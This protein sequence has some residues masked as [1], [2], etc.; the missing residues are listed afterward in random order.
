MDSR[1]TYVP[2]KHFTIQLYLHNSFLQSLETD[3]VS[4]WK[5]KNF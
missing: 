1:N 3:F 2:D 5:I 4:H